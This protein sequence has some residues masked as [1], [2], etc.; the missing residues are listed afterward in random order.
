MCCT[1]V[2]EDEKVLNMVLT[3][4]CDGQPC[5]SEC[6]GGLLTFS[7]AHLLTHLHR[8]VRVIS[9]RP[10]QVCAQFSHLLRDTASGR[11]ALGVPAFSAPLK[12]PYLRDILTELRM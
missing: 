3:G 4:Q 6:E 11:A 7:P 12:A 1:H 9:Q 5:C 8:R 2:L 10:V